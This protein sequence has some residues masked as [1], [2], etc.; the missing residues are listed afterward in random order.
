MFEFI[1]K[2]K[3][4]E[5]KNKRNLLIKSFDFALFKKKLRG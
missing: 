3:L 5:N 4:K 1:D 2:Q